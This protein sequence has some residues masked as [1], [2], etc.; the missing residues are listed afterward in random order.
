MGADRKKGRPDAGASE[1]LHSAANS[2]VERW[3]DR[4][5]LDE[6]RDEEIAE[7][8]SELARAVERIRDGRPVSSDDVDFHD[9]I[10]ANQVARAIRAELLSRWDD[11]TTEGSTDDPEDILDLLSALQLFQ[12]SLWTAPEEEGFFSRLSQ[13]GAYELVVGLA[14]DLRSPLSSVLFLAETLRS[15]HSGSLNEVQKSQLGLIYGAAFGVLSLADDVMEMAKAGRNPS[16]MEPEP[17]AFSVHQ[18]LESVE[19]MVRPMAEEK[20]I[21]LSFEAPPVQP[22]RGQ[23]ELLS[24]V[25]LNLTTN[26]LK[27]TEDGSVTVSVETGRRSVLIFSI[28]DTGK[29][30]PPEKQQTLLEP[31]QYSSNQERYFFSSSGLGLTTVQRL[32]KVMDGE[33]EYETVEGEGTRFFFELDLP[34]AQGL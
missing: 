31:F 34:P 6:A 14:H 32:L 22:R 18:L 26:A 2:V 8:L 15:E 9:S 25:L 27:F 5:G 12:S 16:R 24:R 17:S 29:G 33:L 21:D 10:L 3:R 19:Q 1:L 20:G 13:P 4:H 11:G 30:I 23:P 7:T 28:E